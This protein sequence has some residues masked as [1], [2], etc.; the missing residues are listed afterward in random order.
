MRKFFATLLISVFLGQNISAKSLFYE[1]DYQNVWCSLHNGI[2]EYRNS[3]NTRVDCL[4]KTHAVEFDFAKKWAESVG[5]AE[6]Y[7]M[8]TGK[9]GMVILIIEKPEEMK[10]LKKVIALSK[11]H[12]FD[13]DYVTP[14]IISCKKLK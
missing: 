13:V 9:R 6:Y 14:E 7:S 4:T 5:Q 8:L 2:S 11:I 12:N 1:A 3:D 10:Y